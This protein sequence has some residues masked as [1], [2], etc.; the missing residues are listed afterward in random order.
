MG[1]G[2]GETFLQRQHSYGQ[3]VCEKMLDITNHQE[4]VNQNYN[5]ISPQTY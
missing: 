3:L 1:E 5:E 2:L 4:N